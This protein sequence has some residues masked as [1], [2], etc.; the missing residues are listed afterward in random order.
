MSTQDVTT[1]TRRVDSERG[2]L[3]LLLAM[4]GLMIAALF[5]IGAGLLLFA[6]TPVD[7]NYL[8]D[9]APAMVLIG[10]GAGLAGH[11]H[12]AFISSRRIGGVVAAAGLPYAFFGGAWLLTRPGGGFLDVGRALGPDVEVGLDLGDAIAQCPSGDAVVGGPDAHRTVARHDRHPNG[13][14]RRCTVG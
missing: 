2:A 14:R 4:V 13:V 6:R 5:A 11:A 7:A 10:V 12:W 1:R 3:L 9:I 8:V